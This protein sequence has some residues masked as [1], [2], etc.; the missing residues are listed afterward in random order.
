MKKKLFGKI[1]LAVT[2]VAFG[3]VVNV[4]ADGSGSGS[5]CPDENFCTISMPGGTG[6]SGCCAK[7][8]S[9]CCITCDTEMGP[10]GF[11]G[12]DSDEDKCSCDRYG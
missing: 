12:C 3:V 8:E 9:P 10:R 2:A 7:D 6:T 4:I 11:A 1:T 5:G